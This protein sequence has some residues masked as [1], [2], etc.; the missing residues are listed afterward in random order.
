MISLYSNWWLKPGNEEKAIPL[1][2][3]LAKKVRKSEP[4]TLMYMVHYP[5]QEF[6]AAY[7]F[8]SEPATRPGAITFVECYASW[9]AFDKHFKGD[10]FT[11]FVK[12]H[13][14]LFV[15]K[16]GGT[17]QDPKPFTQV[18]FMDKKAGFIRRKK[19]SKAK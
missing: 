18:V 9:E 3:Q 2:N 11:E 1:L 7:N 12:N 17:E 19:W 15:Q 5:F 8:K 4:D 10:T 6:P 14:Y 16:E 13:G